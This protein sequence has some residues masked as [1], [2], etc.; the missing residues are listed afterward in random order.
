M[1]KI[2][3]LSTKDF[4]DFY[5]SCTP[6]VRESLKKLFNPVIMEYLIYSIK[7]FEDASIR[8]LGKVM[9]FDS[10]LDKQSTAS[11]KLKIISEALNDGWEPENI[12]Y[13]PTFFIEGGIFKLQEIKMGN[14]DSPYM[15]FP[16]NSP[17][18]YF[19]DRELADYVATTFID[20]WKNFYIKLRK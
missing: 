2:I 10:E 1:E 12:Y 3:S 6:K 17:E 5:E 9:E 8:V 13:Y 11:M 4:I 18:F 15:E 20:L 14:I 16:N 19:R 7:T